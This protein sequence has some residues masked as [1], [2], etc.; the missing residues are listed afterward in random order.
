MRLYAVA[1]IAIDRASAATH[2]DPVWVVQRAWS[3]FRLPRLQELIRSTISDLRSLPPPELGGR[4]PSVGFRP[5][6]DPVADALE[7]CCEEL[8][9]A[10]GIPGADA[11]LA[12]HCQK[13]RDCMAEEPPAW[14]EA[15]T[16]A[17]QEYRKAATRALE[18]SFTRG[19][20]G[21]A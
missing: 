18:T 3:V 15:F 1:P 9:D 13:V 12:R 20:A 10:S 17:L 4:E 19:S 5:E 8:R 21:A 6:C 2:H 16:E 14:S 7:A 11:D